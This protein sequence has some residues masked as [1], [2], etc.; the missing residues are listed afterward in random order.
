MAFPQEATAEEAS[1]LKGDDYPE[2]MVPAGYG[3]I[4]AGI[5]DLYEDMTC[6][7]ILN[8]MDKW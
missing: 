7:M 4:T 2:E 5:E 6:E 1:I 3:E 8:M